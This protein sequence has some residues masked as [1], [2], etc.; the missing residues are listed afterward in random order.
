MKKLGVALAGVVAVLIAS[1]A[2]ATVCSSTIMM[3]TGDGHESFSALGAGVCVQAQDK[4]FSNFSFGNLAANGIVT[5]DLEVINA[6][7]NHNITFTD[8]FSAGRTYTGFGYN[9]ANGPSAS[10]IVALKADL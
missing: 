6:A 4:L 10:P 3:P 5:F 7:E 9:V 2:N 1:Q 8:S